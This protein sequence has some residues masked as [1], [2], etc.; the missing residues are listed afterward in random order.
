MRQ[1]GRVD[2]VGQAVDTALRVDER[3][4][5]RALLPVDECERLAQSHM[6]PCPPCLGDA[7]KRR[8]PLG[9]HHRVVRTTTADADP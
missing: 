7:G 4:P 3:V 6:Q 5:R 1:V 8:A 2:R 9:I